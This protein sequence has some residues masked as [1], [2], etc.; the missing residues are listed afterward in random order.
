MPEDSNQRVQRLEESEQRA[1]RAIE[2]LAD[3]QTKL[4]DLMVTLA[5]AQI[6]TEER[7]QKTDERFQKTDERIDKLVSAIGELIRGRNPGQA[8]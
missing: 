5:E 1:W 3:K 4:D 6:L 8:L 2:A 7:F